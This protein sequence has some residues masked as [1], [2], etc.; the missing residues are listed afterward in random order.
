MVQSGQEFNIAKEPIPAFTMGENIKPIKFEKKRL[1]YDFVD[2]KIIEIKQ[3]LR[4]F[5]I[6]PQYNLKFAIIN[7][8]AYISGNLSSKRISIDITKHPG[9]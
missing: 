6:I 9:P 5:E 4:P 8:I 3:G 2:D 7:M 1:S